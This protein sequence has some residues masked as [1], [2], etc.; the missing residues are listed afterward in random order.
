MSYNRQNAIKYA[1]DWVYKRNPKYYDF[2]GIGGDCTNF[3]SQCLLAGGMEMNHKKPLGWFYHSV[4]DR[5]PSWT[6]VHFFYNFLTHNKGVGPKAEDTSLE[7]LIPGDIVQLSFEP[8]VFSHTLLVIAIGEEP[9]LDNVLVATH[10]FD[11]DFRPL[12]TYDVVAYRYLKIKD[13]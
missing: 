3:I 4:H 9:N 12:S 7:Q 1:H 13:D 10:T 6:G 5:S 8:E 11:S 2:S